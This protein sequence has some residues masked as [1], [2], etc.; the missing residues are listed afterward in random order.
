[1]RTLREQ[2]AATQRGQASLVAVAVA[3]LL[4]V[5]AVAV[6]LGLASGAFA[7]AERSA[8]DRHAASTTAAWFIDSDSSV[9]RRGNVLNAS[10]VANLTATRVTQLVPV[11]DSASFRIELG[12]RTIAE[13][14]SPDGGVT[15]RRIVLLASETPRT[16]VVNASDGVTLPRRTN[17]LELGFENASV[18]TV[19]ANGR[20]LLHRS[21]GLSGVAT[22]TVTRR[23][24][25]RV[26]FGPSATGTVRV[27]TFPTRTRKATLEV[28]VDVS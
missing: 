12:G 1:M 9:T 15:I 16:R 24:T 8:E 3:F 19:R 11:L 21:D 28:T 6:A 5:T 2:P 14:G 20:V 26:T 17:R 22:V 7:G 18:E 10:V 23:E 4:V 27:R 13:R 25:L